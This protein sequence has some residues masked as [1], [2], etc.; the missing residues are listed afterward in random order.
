[1]KSEKMRNENNNH[2]KKKIAVFISGGGTNLQ[3]IIDSIARDEINGQITLVISSDP[4]AYG[5]TRAKKHNI[6]VHIAKFSGVTKD[7]DYLKVKEILDNEGI[8]L[9]VLA[10][11]MK[12]M[13]ADFVNSFEKRIINLHPALLPRHGGMGMYGDNVHRAVLDENDKTS[14]ATVHFVDSGCDTGEIIAQGMTNVYNDDSIESLSNRI[15]IIEHRLLPR[16]I[17]DLCE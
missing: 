16:V 12:V 17:A 3:A 11:F 15:H 6:P 10:G 2:P 4:K 5:V 8:E 14:G 13:P 7:D 9:I 1:M